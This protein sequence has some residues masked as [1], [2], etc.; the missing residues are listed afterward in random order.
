LQSQ[1]PPT[2]LTWHHHEDLGRFVLLK[3]SN[4]AE[5]PHWGGRSIWKRAFNVSYP[6][7]CKKKN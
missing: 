1:A 7:R 5:A 6:S 3:K 4:H 2:A